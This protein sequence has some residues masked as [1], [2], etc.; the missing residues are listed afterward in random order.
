MGIQLKIK[1]EKG[2]RKKAACAE[3][4]KLGEAIR[5]PSYVVSYRRIGSRGRSPTRLRYASPR[6]D[7]FESRFAPAA[8]DF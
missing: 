6:Q 5:E 7:G 1:K 4:N 3:A 2:K 8:T